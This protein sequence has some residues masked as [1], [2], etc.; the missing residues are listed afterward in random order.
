[1][2]VWMKTLEKINIKSPNFFDMV[3][4]DGNSYHGKYEGVRSNK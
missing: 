4:T 1:M 2:H 3:H